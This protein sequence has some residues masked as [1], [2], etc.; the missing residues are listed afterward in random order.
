[1]TMVLEIGQAVQLLHVLGNALQLHA[2]E[3]NS[4]LS[5]LVDKGCADIIVLNVGRSE[6]A[7]WL[8]DY[9]VKQN[10]ERG[11]R[12]GIG[13]RIAVEVSLVTADGASDAVF[14]L[15]RLDFV[16]QR[17]DRESG[18]WPRSGRRRHCGI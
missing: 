14:Q 13:G 18:S 7:T 5:V 3:L 16:R 1:M 4:G 15:A 6:L 17:A 2:H 10:Y 8:G 9:C 11:H 12:C